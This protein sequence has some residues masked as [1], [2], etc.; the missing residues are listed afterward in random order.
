MN[1]STELVLADEQ[2]CLGDGE[3]ERE[4]SLEAGVEEKSG[5]LERKR[6]KL[7]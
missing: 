2:H 4:E 6:R 7:I 1:G 5:I 3:E